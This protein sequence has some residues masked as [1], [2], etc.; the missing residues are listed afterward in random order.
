[1]P[2]STNLNVPPYFDDFN[3]QKDYYRIL[4][5]P[6]VSVQVRELNQLQDLFQQQVE[7]FGD[8]IFT[9]G[10]IV[11][12]CN[13]QFYN[14]FP[15]VQ[16]NDV[17]INGNPTSPSSYVGYNIVNE[18]TGLTGIIQNSSN[19]FQTTSPNLK[20]LYLR[21]TNS[22][23]N[24]STLSYNSGDILTI[25]NSVINGISQV[26]VNTGGI[27]FTN[28]NPVV[29]LSQI[30]VTINS[31]S[32]A[33]GSYL[34]NG[35]GANVQVV[36]INTTAFSSSNQVVLQIAPRTV[37][38]AN[39]LANSMSWTLQ[40]GQALTNPAASMT[41][42]L[43][44]TIGA[45]FVGSIVTNGI[46]TI[47]AINALQQGVGYT[48]E[49]FITVQSPGN[50]GGYSSLSLNAQNY[51]VQVVA[52]S[53]G[54]NVGNGY[55]FG[56]TQ[57][58][59]YQK[60][61]FLAVNPQQII[62]S[63]YDILPDNV[64]VGFVTN[65]SIINFNIDTSLVD[66]ANG[67]LNFQAPGADRLQMT[68]VLQLVTANNL[69]GNSQFLP[70]VQWKAGQPYQQNQQTIYSII[71]DKMAETVF[72]TEGNFVIN[73]FL[74]TTR[75]SVATNNESE[76]FNVVIDPGIAYIDGYKVSTTS[77]FNI[78]DVCGTNTIIANNHAISLSYGNYVTC[79]N[80]AGNF[81]FNIGDTVSLYDTAQGFILNR[82]TANA[83]ISSPGG[84]LIGNANIRS[85]LWASG[86]PGTAQATYNLYLFNIQM[87]NGK[88][89]G[90][91]RSI[92][93]GGTNK[94]Q[95]DIVLTVDNNNVS[96]APLYGTSM[97]QLVFYAG[98]SSL[99][100]AN[101]CLY[102]FRTCNSALSIAN[103]NSGSNAIMTYD[104]SSGTDTFPYS[105][106]LSASQM[107]DMYVVNI[108]GTDILANAVA[109]GTASVN[110]ASPN[111]VGTTTTWLST[112]AP[113]DWVTVTGNSTGGGDL[114]Q[115]IQIVN[116]TLIVLNSNVA[117]VN[118]SATFT[119]TFPDYLPI[120]F[121]TRSGLT[122]NVNINQNIL[123]FDFGM[124][125]S[126][127]GNKTGSLST[128]ILRTSNTSQTNKTIVRN[129]YVLIDTANNNGSTSGP[130]C[131]GVPDIFR[132]SGV[133]VGN[134][135]VTNTGTNYVSNFF[136]DHNQNA[137]YYGLG[138]LY[139]SPT[140]GL[141][142][143][144][145]YLLVQF[146]Y[147]TSPGS[148][149]YDTVSYLQTS[150]QSTI[151]AQDSTPYTNLSTN[152]SF[153][154]SF[155]V[156]EVFT[157]DGT[158]IDL[159]QYFDFRPYAAN[160]CAPSTTYSSAPLNPSSTITLAT[161]GEKKFPL[162]N[163]LFTYNIEY[164]IGRQDSVFVDKNGSFSVLQ[165]NPSVNL[166]LQN[167]PVQPDG[168]MEIVTLIVPPYPTLPQN[169]SASLSQILHT[170]MG[171]HN[172]LLTTRVQNQTISTPS[173]NTTLPFLQPKIYTQSAIG[174][175][176][177]RLSDVENYVALNTLQVAASQLIIP[178]SVNPSENRFQYG[179]FVDNFTTSDFSALTDPQYA[180]TLLNGNI[181]PPRMEWDLS[182]YGSGSANW[183]EIKICN[184]PDATTG[185][186]LDPQG[187]GPICALNLANTV[188]Y[189]TLFRN[190]EDATITSNGGLTDTVNLTFADLTSIQTSIQTTTVSLNQWLQNNQGAIYNSVGTITGPFV[191]T[192]YTTDVF[193]A[194]FN[195]SGQGFVTTG[196]SYDPSSQTLTITS[197]G[198]AI[199]EQN[200][201]TTVTGVPES[202]ATLFGELLTNQI[203]A[204][205]FIGAI[206]P[207][208]AAPSGGANNGGIYNPPVAFYFYN[209]NNPTL[210]Q[211]YQN[212][213]LIGS[214]STILSG[215]VATP[216][217]LSNSD[218]ALLT[219]PTADSWFNDSTNLYL[220]TFND[221][222][223]GYVT[224]AGKILFNYNPANGDNI[225]IVSS[226]PS[227]QEI[228]RW[229]IAYPIDG[230]SIGCVP[231]SPIGQFATF[232]FT[233]T[234][235]NGN[236]AQGTVNIL[237]GLTNVW[238]INNGNPT[239]S[240]IPFDTSADWPA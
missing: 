88:N 202:V 7:R 56:V 58:V 68:P 104:I 133:Y 41:A 113:G 94:G 219:G 17:D 38:L 48:F 119:R 154:N 128:N 185:G 82:S 35:S 78:D 84:N 164:Y 73:P 92:Y 229:V 29:A 162:P 71:G 179:I 177:R 33:N 53:G 3:S 168:T 79:N 190:A 207:V 87:A 224:Y 120:P 139:Q 239:S 75:S 192:P 214:T 46:G 171:N 222:G 226:S 27:S 240:I 96:Y 134:S 141:N 212:G 8:N 23:S 184:Q 18:T 57:G 39:S 21:Y 47:T 91:V 153:I 147:F 51:L 180:A 142:V 227:L 86:E 42:A 126:Y 132:L 206:Q 105:G 174:N 137:D 170:N 155:E 160:T 103:N 1:M 60:G 189:T 116:N 32:I 9:T 54:N 169:Y 63:P 195:N 117:F 61:Y 221:T 237:T 186:V 145:S 181:V 216:Q 191:S 144:N 93:Y 201:V 167:P 6:G 138:Y 136:I 198:P 85:L 150:N 175:L 11:S 20:T 165:G 110:G 22:G 176:D 196:F 178:S 108:S 97:D 37:D 146:S 130:W 223:S 197:S 26:N 203:T 66:N 95:A 24:G 69:T 211:I 112:F 217:A 50:G 15:F 89:F 236:E 210:Y 100:N 34:V 115:I 129:A 228:W 131:M 124:Q 163:S 135:S 148:G 225:Q 159:L 157:D 80:F 140:S 230:S 30:I 204:S 62:V 16:I 231:P 151:F 13:F 122:A 43:N 111:A 4:F 235:G 76:F 114:H 220:K 143:T 213:T 208:Q 40:N 209:Y 161:S 118:A 55:A 5:Q 121:G 25:Y 74:V 102:T 36:S 127:S 14:P 81:Q 52:A 194:L 199:N 233:E 106:A 19:G 215:S 49:P 218:I 205:Q 10:T 64:A 107:T 44:S 232:N 188:A 77:N 182:T 31:G 101:N 123:T 187:V 158:E 125:F 234:C 67:T 156:P 45:G 70:I 98:V 149:F 59:I 193:Q 99:K 183:I 109:T 83:T 28:S 238:T 90:S 166:S 12:G 65:E 72:D 172:N 152:N 173:S 200:I 2:Q